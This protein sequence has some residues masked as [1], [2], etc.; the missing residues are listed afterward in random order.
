M[1]I[2]ESK[3]ASERQQSSA[4]ERKT[5]LNNERRGWANKK[6]LK[7]QPK[8]GETELAMYE[9]TWS[10]YTHAANMSEKKASKKTAMYRLQC[11]SCCVVMLLA[12]D[13]HAVRALSAPTQPRQPLSNQHRDDSGARSNNF[14][15]IWIFSL[16]SSVLVGISSKA[17]AFCSCRVI[18]SALKRL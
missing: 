1:I 4:K 13:V 6:E 3:E 11:I 10:W 7:K 17:V 14:I 8:G 15:H 9:H 18:K 5:F 16:L 12:I 2:I